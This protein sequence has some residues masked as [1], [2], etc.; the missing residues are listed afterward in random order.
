MVMGAPFCRDD[1]P[2]IR[3]GEPLSMPTEFEKEWKEADS[4]YRLQQVGTGLRLTLVG[5]DDA[6]DYCILSRRFPA[7]LRL[8]TED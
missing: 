3:R 5:K 4:P 2:I 8:T 7:V 6:L 1:V